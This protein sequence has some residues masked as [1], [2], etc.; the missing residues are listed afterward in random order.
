MENLIKTPDLWN[1]VYIDGGHDDAA[2]VENFLMSSAPRR[3]DLM[4]RTTVL[5]VVYFESSTMPFERFPPAF[6]V[7]LSGTTAD[8]ISK[9]AIVQYGSNVFHN[10]KEILIDET[11]G[12][13]WDSV[14]GGMLST[15]TIST[16]RWWNLESSP[17][18]ITAEIHDRP[19][20]MFSCR[21]HGSWRLGNCHNPH[22]C[23]SSIFFLQDEVIEPETEAE[24][25][26]PFCSL[27][28]PLQHLYIEGRSCV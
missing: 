15:C 17:R 2:R 7:F 22:W 24:Q 19:N 4:I 26:T 8:T 23:E 6:A 28:L 10:V 5:K 1:R 16:F 21:P 13:E 18:Q 14:I 3:I 9:E 12:D 20:V 25:N 27:L 11:A